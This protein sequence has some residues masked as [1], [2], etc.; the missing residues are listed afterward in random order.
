MERYDRTFKFEHYRTLASLKDYILI[1]QDRVKLGHKARRDDGAWER[2]ET[3]ELE[4][5]IELPSIGCAFRVADAYELVEF[6]E[7]E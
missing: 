2:R 3:Q 6:A 4:G 1:A 7:T 5:L